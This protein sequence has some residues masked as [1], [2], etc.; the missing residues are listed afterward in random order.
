MWPAFS[1]DL[2]TIEHL[3]NETQRRINEV[4]QLGA[5][6]L[7]VWAPIYHMSHSFN[8]QWKCQKSIFHF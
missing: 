4:R 7:M 1:L 5:Y 8:V 3:W 6:F 2:N